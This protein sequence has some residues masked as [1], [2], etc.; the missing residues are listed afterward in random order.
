MRAAAD[1]NAGS[2][3]RARRLSQSAGAVFLGFVVVV[4]LS[5]GTDHVLH[6]LG[7]YPPWGEAMHAPRLNLL[8][9]SYRC[10]YA[11][12]GSYLAARFAPRHPMRHALILGSIGFVLSLLGAI[13][14]VS[15]DLGPAWYPVAL[16]LTALPCAWLGGVLHRAAHGTR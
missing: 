14:A 5:L 13:A 1:L 6:V 16:V 2:E 10:V 12:I 4:L 9:L 3:M 15:A 11:V 8:A 7:V